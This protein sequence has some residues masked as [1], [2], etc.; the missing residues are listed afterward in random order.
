M[1]HVVSEQWPPSEVAL[2][3]Q[4]GDVQCKAVLGEH[5]GFLTTYTVPTHLH[6]QHEPRQTAPRI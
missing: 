3:M 4:D 2:C 1:Q 5:I 6:L